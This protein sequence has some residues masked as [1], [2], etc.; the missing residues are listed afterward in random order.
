MCKASLPFTI[1][2]IIL[3]GNG[4]DIHQKIKIELLCD[5]AIPPPVVSPEVRICK[6]CMHAHVYCNAIRN[7]QYM[8]TT[9]VSFGRMDKETGSCI[10]K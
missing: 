7:S 3:K 10:Y 1:S 5:P 8:E 2:G 6:R 4:V 9:Q